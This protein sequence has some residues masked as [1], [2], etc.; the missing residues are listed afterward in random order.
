M[1]RCARV[2]RRHHASSNQSRAALDANPKT[3]TAPPKI[4]ATSTHARRHTCACQK[5]SSLSPTHPHAC[6][7][8]RGELEMAV[9]EPIR[10]PDRFAALGLPAATGVLLYGEEGG[11]KGEG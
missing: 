10:H 2:L 8:I 4:T 7:Q 9:T 11:K 5:P 1:H 6:A 3:P